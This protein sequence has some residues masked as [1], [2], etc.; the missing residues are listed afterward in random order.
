VNAFA[1]G[2]VEAEEL[3]RATYEMVERVKRLDASKTYRAAV[4]LAEPVDADAFADA[5]DE[6]DGATI[7]QFTPQR[8]DHRRA[9]TTRTREVYAMSGDLDDSTHATVEIRGAG[10]LYVKEL[11]S[12]DDGRTEPSLAGL[13]G[14]DAHVTDLDVLAVEGEDES[15][16]D[17]A[18]FP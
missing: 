16:E 15:F 4:A 17:E 9:N 18:Y 7:E 13:L 12:G 8:V 2:A 14:V 1:D 6:L 10:G 5:L 11:V 3:R